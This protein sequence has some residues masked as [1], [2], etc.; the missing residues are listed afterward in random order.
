[1]IADNAK[2]DLLKASSVKPVPGSAPNPRSLAEKLSSH[3][4]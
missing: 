3:E 2:V 1:M 4:R